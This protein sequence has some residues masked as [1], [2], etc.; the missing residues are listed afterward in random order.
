MAMIR[1]G[2]GRNLHSAD[3]AYLTV[4]ADGLYT[5]GLYFG[6]DFREVPSERCFWQ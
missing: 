1:A 4:F 3:A 6:L 2:E 5:V